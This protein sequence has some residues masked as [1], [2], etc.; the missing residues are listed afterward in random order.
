MS[1]LDTVTRDIA[2]AMRAKDTI[3]LGALR[4]LKAAL[5]NREVERG[6]PLDEAESLKVV[7]SLVKQ[8]RDSIEQ[9]GAAGRTDLV[10]K[11]RAEL[12]VIERYQPPSA[13]PDA[14]ARLVDEAAVELGAGSPKDMG[15]VMKAVMERLAGQTADGRVVSDLVKK[16]LSR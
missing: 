12:E 14:I 10:E 13:T 11:E 2:D 6:R 9:F 16:R 3:R 7:A 15:R 1:L 4:L 8:R 5:V